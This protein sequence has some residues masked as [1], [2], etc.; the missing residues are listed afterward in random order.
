L[1]CTI[2]GI[3]LSIIIA[4]SLSTYLRPDNKKCVPVEVRDELKKMKAQSYIQN[5]R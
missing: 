5:N 2:I 1:F 4:K 3:P